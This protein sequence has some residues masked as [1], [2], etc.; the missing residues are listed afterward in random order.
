MRKLLAI[1]MVLC[2]IVSLSVCAFAAE[3]NNVQSPT[4]KPIDDPGSGNNGNN[5]PQT[6]DTLMF[7]GIVLAALVALCGGVFATK[8][9]LAKKN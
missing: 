4:D 8:K 9:L 1:I 2:L 3:D 6:G 7:V 5:S